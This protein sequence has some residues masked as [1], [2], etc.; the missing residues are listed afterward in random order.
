[1]AKRNATFCDLCDLEIKDA[2][3]EEIKKIQIDDNIYEET[4]QKC[5]S[6]LKRTVEEIKNTAK[7]GPKR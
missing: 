2:E 6:K 3:I 4:C 1:M 5:R 7:H